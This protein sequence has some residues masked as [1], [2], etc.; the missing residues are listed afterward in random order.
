MLLMFTISFFP[1]LS[2]VGRARK[3]MAGRSV[4]VFDGIEYYYHQNS[5][6][7]W[8]KVA[9]VKDYRIIVLDEPNRIVLDIDNMVGSQTMV[10]KEVDAPFVNL[11]RYA[12][13]DK[14]T[15]KD[16]NLN[17]NTFRIVLDVI[18]DVKFDLSLE[19]EDL[20]IKVFQEGAT[21]IEL[22]K[23]NLDKDN[24]NTNIDRLG[25]V[26]IN[27]K[28]IEQVVKNPIEKKEVDEKTDY[29]K[30]PEVDDTENNNV[31]EDEKN[32]EEIEK[33]KEIV[34][35]LSE[36]KLEKPIKK[37]LGNLK[38]VNE[39]DRKALIVEGGL[40]TLGTRNIVKRY[41]S[42]YNENGNIYTISFSNVLASLKEG[43][44]EIN[45]GTINS[46]E[47]IK[48]SEQTSIVIN[49]T[50]KFNYHVISRNSVKNTAITILPK[51]K[52]E[53]RVVVIDSGH[54]GVDPGAVYQ[55]IREGELNLDIAIF[56]NDLLKEEGVQ[57]YML[58]EEDSYLSTYER[59][60]IAN[61][62]D[63]KLFLSIHNNAALSN[64]ARG[65][66]T[67]YFGPDHTSFNGKDFA[68]ILQLNMVQMLGT[69]DRGIISRPELVVLR[70]TRMPA[71]LVEIGFMTNPDDMKM[72]RSD[73]FKQKS[74]QSLKKSILETLKALES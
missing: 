71:A 33:E 39:G 60:Y 51:L 20:I 34:K 23:E 3:A 4:S 70:Q 35:G 37:E 59:A 53:Q 61:A 62:L 29:E 13:I 52:A 28:E 16:G 74:A 17:P 50:E 15:A 12:Q 47:V 22:P 41:T 27:E 21:K 38:Y 1:N 2:E 11:V 72:L 6:F 7:L 18:D 44:L 49:A 67:L 73:E 8:L 10:R 30:K 58:R 69:V 68:K 64:V 14:E 43:V 32:D 31:K 57:T 9:A 54:G 55:G 63:A 19:N 66:E 36:N 45:D 48:N 26:E 24:Q 25:S 46:V 40:L 65:S 56:L 42:K 5:G